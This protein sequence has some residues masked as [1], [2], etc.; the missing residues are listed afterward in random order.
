MTETAVSGASKSGLEHWTTNTLGASKASVSQ[1][2]CLQRSLVSGVNWWSIWS[3]L[4]PDA[5][6][7]ILSHKTVFFSIANLVQ[8]AGNKDFALCKVFER[9]SLIRKQ[10]S[11]TLDYKSYVSFKAFAAA[12]SS[13]RLTTVVSGFVFI[14]EGSFSASL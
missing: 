3:G 12:T 6:T 7:P 10:V 11:F 14:A 2:D 9:D 5:A 13:G 8:T 4:P 1:V